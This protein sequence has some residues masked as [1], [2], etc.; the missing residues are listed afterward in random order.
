M[1][2]EP[3]AQREENPSGFQVCGGACGQGPR[4]EQ[5]GTQGLTRRPEAEESHASVDLWPRHHPEGLWGR[6]EPVGGGDCRGSGLFSRPP[7]TTFLS[8]GTCPGLLEVQRGLGPGG[9][10]Q[11]QAEART[12]APEH[13]GRGNGAG[14][15]PTCGWCWCLSALWS[16]GW[17]DQELINRVGFVLMLP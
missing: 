1:V 11:T 7:E 12:W 4:G 13:R 3:S 17:R 8:S 16:L 10:R 2:L 15:V 9:R 14:G 6:G 5:V